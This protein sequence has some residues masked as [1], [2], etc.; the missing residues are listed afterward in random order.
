MEHFDAINT[1]IGIKF[2]KAI[3]NTITAITDNEQTTSGWKVW[4][5]RVLGTE[6]INEHKYLVIH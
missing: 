2:L 1:L 5:V 4:E 6:G 3:I